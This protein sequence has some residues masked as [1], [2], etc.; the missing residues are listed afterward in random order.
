MDKL[1]I[2]R[3]GRVEAFGPPNEVLVRLVRPANARK[4]APSEP[5][6]ESREPRQQRGR[7]MIQDCPAIHQWH[8]D[9]QHS[10]RGPIVIGTADTA[11]LGG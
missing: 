10:A 8:R 11:D 6:R 9:V 5:A 4:I 1:L 2:L 3:D 7:A